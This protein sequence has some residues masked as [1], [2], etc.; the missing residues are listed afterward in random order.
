MRLLPKSRYQLVIETALLL[1]I[2][3][4]FA[5]LWQRRRGLTAAALA[6]PS[7]GIPAAERSPV[8]IVPAASAANAARTAKIMQR[9]M[10]PSYARTFNDLYDNPG[11]NPLHLNDGQIEALQDCC[12]QLHLERMELEARLA[13]TE[14]V[15]GGGVFIEI[16]PYPDE[17]RILKQ[18][19]IASLVQ[20]FGEALAG[21]IQEQYLRKIELDNEELGARPQQILASPDPDNPGRLKV[22]YS[23]SWPDSGNRITRTSSLGAYDYREFGALGALFPKP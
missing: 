15:E 9:S 12:N 6:K 11:S 16:P 3:A 19:F 8:R 5:V 2:V 7:P 10:S 14:T 18:E 4:T 22:V 17:G 1:A 13:K 21:E 23:S 20:Q